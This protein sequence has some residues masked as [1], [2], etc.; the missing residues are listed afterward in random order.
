MESNG[1]QGDLIVA[2]EV[3]FD[4]EKK[5]FSIHHVLN[6]VTVPLFPSAIITN[7][8][9]KIYLPSKDSVHTLD[10]EV[11]DAMNKLIFYESIGKVSNVRT[12][13]GYGMRPGIDKSV[14]CRFPVTCQGTYTFKLYSDNQ[15][16][17]AYP[18]FIQA[19]E[20]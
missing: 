16:L 19:M 3:F 5:C 14:I 8:F 7:L 20:E 17:C 9:I 11:T 18:L 2:D 12:N 10:I 4:K 13:L 1:L 15:L 6:A